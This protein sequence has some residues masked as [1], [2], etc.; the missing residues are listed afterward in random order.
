MLHAWLLNKTNLM[1]VVVKIISKMIFG[2]KSKTTSLCF[3][4]D[5]KIKLESKSQKNS[6]DSKLHNK[7]KQNL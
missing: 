7:S 3:N 4:F 2:D 1:A 6:T 5:I